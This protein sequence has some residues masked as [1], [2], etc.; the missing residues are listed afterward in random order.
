MPATNYTLILFAIVAVT[1]ALGVYEAHRTREDA[2][3]QGIMRGL[4]E[5]EARRQAPG[6]VTSVDEKVRNF[7]T[8]REF[9]G[10]IS[11]IDRVLRQRT[12]GMKIRYTTKAE[13]LVSWNGGEI[14]V[15]NKRFSIEN[16]PTVVH[17]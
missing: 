16:I 13:G 3:Q 6:V 9:G 11:L 14:L 1:R 2:V 8:L 7:T 12:Y 10:T 17:D 4:V 15:D 5:K